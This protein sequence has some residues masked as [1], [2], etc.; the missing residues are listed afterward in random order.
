M[1]HKSS[2]IF[3]NN[4]GLHVKSMNEKSFSVKYL[5]NFVLLHEK[6]WKKVTVTCTPAV[7]LRIQKGF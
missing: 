3:E 6:S 2:F 5:T 7:P 1:E 4:F